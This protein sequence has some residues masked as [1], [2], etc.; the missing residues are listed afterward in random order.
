VQYADEAVVVI[1]LKPVKASNGVEDKTKGT[2][3]LVIVTVASQ[4]D[5]IDAKG[6]RNFKVYQEV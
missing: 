4:K 1:N 5:V 3:F 2:L 6:R